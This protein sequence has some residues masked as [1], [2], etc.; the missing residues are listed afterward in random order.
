VLGL[1]GNPVSTYVCAFLF[2]VP[3]LRKLQGRTDLMHLNEAA[4]LGTDLAANDARQDYLRAKIERGPDGR[5]IATAFQRQDSAMQAF[6][7]DAD[8]LLIR[9]PH[10]PAAKEGD[11]CEVMRFAD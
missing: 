4:F 10:A 1:P 7:K 3:L 8:G 5:L 2:V 6:L 9:A 11:P